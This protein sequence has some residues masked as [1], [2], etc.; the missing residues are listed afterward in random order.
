MKSSL[1]VTI[2][3]ITMPLSL[4][5]YVPIYLLLAALICIVDGGFWLWIIFILACVI[6]ISANV[7]SIIDRLDKLD[8]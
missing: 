1:A 8:K 2:F 5:G 4:I 7:I 6:Q 3:L